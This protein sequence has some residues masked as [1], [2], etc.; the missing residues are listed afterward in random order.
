MNSHGIIEASKEVW[1]FQFSSLYGGFPERPC[2]L[3]QKHGEQEGRFM[4]V[5]MPAYRVPLSDALREDVLERDAFMCAYCDGFADTVDH[6]V[7]YAYCQTHDRDNLVAACMDC[8]LIASDKI[9][10]SLIHKRAYIRMKRGKGKWPRKLRNRHGCCNECGEP[11]CEG[12]NGATRFVCAKCC[13]KLDIVPET[14]QNRM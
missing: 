11:F 13:V 2:F 14:L 1:A 10:D 8:N 9:F 3:R 7:P 6:I 12:S 4:V 5:V